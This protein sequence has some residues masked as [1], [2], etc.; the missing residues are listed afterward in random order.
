MF[1]LS[2][3]YHFDGTDENP[4]SE[5]HWKNY[6]A[7]TLLL[8][9][10]KSKYLK[11]QNDQFIKTDRPESRVVCKFG[12]ILKEFKFEPQHDK[13]NKMVCVPS[14]DTLGAQII[15]LVLSWG[16]T[17]E[18][19][20]KNLKK[21]NHLKKLLL[22]SWNLNSEDLLYRNV[23][24]RCSLNG[25]LSR[26]RSDCFLRRCVLKEQSDLGLHCLPKPVCPSV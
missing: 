3:F 22:L 15:L 26:P 1:C 24:K 5:D 11:C 25:K 6:S 7:K 20:C 18:N 10:C 17:F 8:I 23:S 19:Y 12:Y 13:T 21:K 4:C 16:G 9:Y 14:K 2:G